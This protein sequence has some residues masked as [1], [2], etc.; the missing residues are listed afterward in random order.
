MNI[1]FLTDKTRQTNGYAIVGE[2]IRRT[3]ENNFKCNVDCFSTDE[4]WRMRPGKTTLRSTLYENYGALAIAWDLLMLI[5]YGRG[6]KYDIIHCNVEHFAVVA[7]LYSRIHKIPYTLTAHGTYGVV[8]PKRYRL[9]A[10][11]FREASR[12]IAVSAFTMRRMHEEGINANIEVIGNGVDK[13]KF[14]PDQSVL[15]RPQFLFI[16]NDKPRKG[17]SFL[18]DALCLIKKKGLKP[19][20]IIVGSFGP[21]KSTVESHALKDGVNIRFAGKVSEKEL[22]RLYQESILNILPSRSEPLYFEGYGLIHA[23]AI[24]AGT[25]TLGCRNSGNEEAIRPGNGWLIDHGDLEALSTKMEELLSSASKTDSKP[26]GPTP[27]E[28]REVTAAYIDIFT[29]VA[30]SSSK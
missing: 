11:A 15:K 27:P 8:L 14:Y 30:H 9:F 17:F 2:N 24:A 23:E 6:S 26:T 3:L 29:S 21:T 5:W 28:W 7:W 12:V 18:Y 4:Y 20:L 13:S 22:L 16:G 10:K 1:L 25:L 19:E